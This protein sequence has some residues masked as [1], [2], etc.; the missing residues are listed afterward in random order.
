MTDTTH[1]DSTQPDDATDAQPETDWR[2]EYDVDP[3]RIRD[4]VAEALA[5]LDPGDPL[6]IDYRDVVTAAGHS[7]PTAAGAYRVAQVGLDAL[8]PDE[9]P[10]RG[11]VA[12]LAGGPKTD[13]TYGVMTRLVSFVTGAAGADGFGGLA[14]GYGGRRDL[15][16]YGDFGG[17]DPAFAF[18]RTDT[19]EAVEVTYRVGSVPEGGPAT[20]A[21]PKL[22]D[23]TA[24]DDERAAF[25]ADWH[26]RVQAVLSD[27]DLFAVAATDREW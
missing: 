10:V 21:L 19:D 5:V 8:Y 1:T 18:R 20:G 9:L 4:P 3:I 14:G 16:A 7:C 26:G 12:V 2:V 17:A 6:V 24:T 25:R 23:G 27:D 22:I 13:A 15:L 11:D